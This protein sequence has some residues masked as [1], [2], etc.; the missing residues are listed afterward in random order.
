MRD[1][2]KFYKL[3]KQAS[4]NVT[5]GLLSGL[6]LGMF[7]ATPGEKINSVPDSKHPSTFDRLIFRF[8]ITYYT[9]YNCWLYYQ[10]FAVPILVLLPNKVINLAK[11]TCLQ[12]SWLASNVSCPILLTTVAIFSNL[13]SYF[14][15]Y[16]VII[17]FRNIKTI[18]TKWFPFKCKWKFRSQLLDPPHSRRA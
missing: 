18:T 5:S 13:S 1:C 8:I 10:Y 15:E 16:S 6:A 17:I 14:C 7:Q 11:L 3:L 9:C 2:I 4:S 12:H